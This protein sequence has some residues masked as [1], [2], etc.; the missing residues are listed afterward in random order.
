MN[1]IEIIRLNGVDYVLV[2]ADHV[3]KIAEITD[4]TNDLS[5]YDNTTSGFITAAALNVKQNKILYGKSS[6]S[7]SLGENG[8]VYLM[9]E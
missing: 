7:S 3:H 9:L 5:K 8:D 1:T 2:P 6:P 4:F